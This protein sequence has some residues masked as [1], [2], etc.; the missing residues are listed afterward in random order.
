MHKKGKLRELILVQ[1]LTLA[2][3]YLIVASKSVRIVIDEVQDV[4]VY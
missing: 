2:V 1:E 3:Y 4:S